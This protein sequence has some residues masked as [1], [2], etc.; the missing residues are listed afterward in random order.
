[1]SNARQTIQSARDAGA[2]QHAPDLLAVAEK[3]LDRA[4]RN[5]EQGDY[6]V[7]RDLALAAQEQAMNARHKA[8]EKSGN[9]PQND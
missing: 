4:A 5:L 3:L 2:E 1:M 9:R 6:H 7:A 8:M